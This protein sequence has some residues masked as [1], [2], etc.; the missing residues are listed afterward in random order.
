MPSPHLVSAGTDAVNT[1]AYARLRERICADI[2]AGVWPLGSRM[3]L[4]KL[5]AHYAVSQNPVREALFQLRGEG[6]VD[7]RSH[8]GVTI[9]RVDGAYIANVYELR[10][11]VERLLTSNAAL[12]ATAEQLS[13]METACAAYEAAAERQEAAQVIAANRAFHRALYAAAGNPV[14][15]A[16]MEA[17]S[18]LVDTVRAAVGYGEGRLQTAARQ[19]RA[20]VAAIRRRDAERAGALAVAHTETSRNDLLARF[21]RASRADS[22]KEETRHDTIPEPAGVSRRGPRAR[23]RAAA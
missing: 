3:T 15:V 19:H 21:A 20:I 2:V 12:R 23:H 7:L 13:A 9:P 1:P 22:T 8:Q 16:A 10:G 14:A 6:I 4:A 17:R 18:T 5:A 11:A